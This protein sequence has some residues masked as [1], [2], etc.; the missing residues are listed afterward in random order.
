MALFAG[1]DKAA[2]G[3]HEAVWGDSFT[4]KPQRRAADVN[5]RRRMDTTRDEVT[6]TA[7]YRQEVAAINQ[8]DAWDERTDRRPGVSAHNHFI[9]ID[10][11]RWPAVA[12]QVG[13]LVQRTDDGARWR[14][15]RVERDDMGRVV[16]AVEAV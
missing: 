13:D 1:L 6:F 9:D 2:Q 5:A 15:A 7:I 8:V 10:P 14:V 16:L 11:R 3:V 12:P 4:L